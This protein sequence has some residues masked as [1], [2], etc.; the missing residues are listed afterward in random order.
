MT[1]FHPVDVHVG[2]RLR[3]RRRMLGLSQS[4]LATQA[5]IT[6]QQV[7]KYE[8]GA[9]RVSASRLWEFASVL[10]VSP[11]YF[12]DG[13]GAPALTNGDAAELAELAEREA[14][15]RAVAEEFETA[16][17]LDR[18]ADMAPH[19]RAASVKLISQALDMAEGL[20]AAIAMRRPRAAA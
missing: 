18:L 14:A 17:L 7:Q 10:G 9:N 5:A 11:A 8:R 19:V 20:V 2:N 1:A 3:T 15:R 13:L 4:T 6:F 16:K 12:F